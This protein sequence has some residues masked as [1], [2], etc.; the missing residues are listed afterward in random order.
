MQ[1]EISSNRFLKSSY[2]HLI[3]ERQYSGKC[4]CPNLLTS[5]Q[6]ITHFEK[7]SSW[8]YEQGCIFNLEWYPEGNF[9]AAATEDGHILF[10][11]PRSS[12]L[13]KAIQNAHYDCI[14]IIRFQLNNSFC[15]FTGSDDQTVKQFDIRKMTCLKIFYGHRGWVKNLENLNQV[16]FFS[17]FFF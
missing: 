14:N 15:F 5:P 11:D 8:K 9:C 10:V 2:F 16:F 17:F 1:N 7:F 13:N 4:H 6:L 12:K 3:H